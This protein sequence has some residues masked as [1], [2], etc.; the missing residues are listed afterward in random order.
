MATSAGL[1]ALGVGL[2]ALGAFGSL[3]L[4]SRPQVQ[5]ADGPATYDCEGKKIALAA[6]SSLRP[7]TELTGSARAAL[8][9]AIG[10]GAADLPSWSVLEATP[11]EVGL[12][13]RASR[14]ELPGQR[15]SYEL[16]GI[17]RGSGPGAEA[18]GWTAGPGSR[19]V[20]TRVLRGGEP[21]VTELDPAADPAPAS[22]SLQLV[23]RGQSCPAGRSK[24]PG[25]QPVELSWTD[26]RLELV[27][28]A[29]RTG[30]CGWTAP[31]PLRIDLDRPLGAREIYD[32]G[33]YPP[34]R[35][36]PAQAETE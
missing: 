35:L 32:A 8:E 9:S 3:A 1:R 19:C 31:A 25:V 22:A 14:R 33:S 18:H 29:R 21:V 24:P 4:T 10:P 34:R 20:L 5:P 11:E 23:V 27:V 26:T 2:I 16:V 7:A 13:R 15:D 30:S 12:I 6:L 36:F 17:S 28:G